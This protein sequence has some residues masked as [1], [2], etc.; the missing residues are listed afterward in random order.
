MRITVRER[1]SGVPLTRATDGWV[2]YQAL[3]LL[4]HNI[5][6]FKE[7]ESRNEARPSTDTHK[8]LSPYLFNTA[9]G[10]HRTHIIIYMHG[11]IVTHTH[12]L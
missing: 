1:P 3:P 2:P 11:Y 8:H 5:A 6:K 12:T 9:R 10:T 4:Q 7:G